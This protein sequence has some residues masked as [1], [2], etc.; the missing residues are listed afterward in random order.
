M[1]GAT[2]TGGVPSRIAPFEG[3]PCL[4]GYHCQT[5]SLANIFYHAGHPVSEDR[6]LGLGAG[7]GYI[8]WQMRVGG[9][10]YVFTGGRGNT[11]NFFADIAERTGIRITEK[12]TSSAKRAEEALLGM[13][14]RE[15]P[16]LVFA[17]MGLLP[18]FELP[19]DYHF[20]GHSF[21]VCG[22][23]GRETV[24]AADIDQKAPGL[25]KGFYSTMTLEQLRRARGSTFK[26]F[27]PKNAWLEFDFGGYR[28]PGAKDY[29]SAIRQAV[30]SQLR[31]PIKNIGVKGL[32]HTA[33][34]ILKWPESLDDRSLRMN[35][36]S[37]YVFIEIGGTGGGCFRHIYSRFLK[38]AAA[39]TGKAALADASELFVVSGEKFTEVGLMFRESE[40]D[41]GIEDKIKAASLIFEDIA[42]IEE[43]AY[44][45]LDA[46]L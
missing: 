14:E 3:C 17:D 38:E 45:I 4:D 10:S 39:V 15:E 27:P 46:N 21:V 23:D 20:G 19:K 42:K 9:E 1:V 34:E 13:M 36:F 22:F 16:V 29:L 41:P 8:Y 44:A 33:R 2:I 37:L 7:M 32:R 40:S 26:P 43:G 24:L 12:R 30:D 35:L 25:K 31:P 6:L 18:W 11:K 28:E 5:N